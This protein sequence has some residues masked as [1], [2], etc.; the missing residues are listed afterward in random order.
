VAGQGHEQQGCPGDQDNGT[1][2]QRGRG[3][4]RYEPPTAAKAQAGTGAKI[5][6][7]QWSRPLVQHDASG[8][9]L[10]GGRSAS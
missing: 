6:D 8:C 5:S 4:G 7:S 3:P 10:S 1:P 2:E 9:R